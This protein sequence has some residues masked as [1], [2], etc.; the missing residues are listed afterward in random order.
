MYVV[1]H[2]I[3]FNFGVQIRS[4]DGSDDVFE[5]FDVNEVYINECVVCDS[6]VSQNLLDEDSE[7]E[8]GEIE[9]QV[10]VSV[11]V[12]VQLDAG[13]HGGQYYYSHR[14]FSCES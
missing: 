9:S 3:L 5:S 11:M 6:T 12:S 4:V 13:Y 8:D 7:M 1:S 10:S 14:W 2:Q